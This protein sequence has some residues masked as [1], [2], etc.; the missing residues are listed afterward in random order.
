MALDSLKKME[1]AWRTPSRIA[2]PGM[3]GEARPCRLHSPRTERMTE[4]IAV[5]PSAISV[6][7]QKKTP[8]E[9]AIL[10]PT[11]PAPIM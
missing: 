7:T 6:Q 9:L 4:K 5:T 10:P 8:L 2:Q 3:D 1:S 11:S